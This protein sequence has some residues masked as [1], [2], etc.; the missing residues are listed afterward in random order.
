VADNDEHVTPE[1]AEEPWTEPEE[2][3]SGLRD[4]GRAARSLAAMALS[5]EGL[6]LLLAIVPMRMILDDSTVAIVA[7]LILVVGCIV[8]AGMTRRAWVWPAGTVLQV[9]LIACWAIHWALGVA[10]IVFGLV[11]VYCWYVKVALGKPPKR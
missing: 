3:R 7:I 11:W 4:P 5:F 6:A 10:G 2:G 9:A 8:L 1:E